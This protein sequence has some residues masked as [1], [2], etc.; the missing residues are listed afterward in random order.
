MIVTMCLQY[1]R[2]LYHTILLVFNISEI[3]T[4]THKLLFEDV[5][6][7]DLSQQ[8]ELMGIPFIIMGKKKFACTHGVDRNR[9]L[10]KQK[11]YEKVEKVYICIYI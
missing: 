8:I 3:D 9:S 2:I 11:I 6:V 10:K 4:G 5:I 1:F 7:K